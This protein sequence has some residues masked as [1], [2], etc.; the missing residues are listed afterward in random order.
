MFSRQLYQQTITLLCYIIH[1]HY[2]ASQL[3]KIYH[4]GSCQKLRNYVQVCKS[5]AE[6]TVD[7]F[8]YR[9]NFIQ[10]KQ[11]YLPGNLHG[12]DCGPH[13]VRGALKST[14]HN[15]AEDH[16]VIIIIIIHVS[17]NDP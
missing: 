14:L 5:Y 15:T 6:K 17:R 13:Q 1:S 12:A 4:D 7:S 3:L 8:H 9:S 11:R 2:T 16:R 10:R